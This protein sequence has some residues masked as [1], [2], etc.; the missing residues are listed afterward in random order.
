L[1][2]MS[3]VLLAGSREW[4]A[5]V[6]QRPAFVRWPIYLALSYTLAMF[7]IWSA[8]PRFVYFAF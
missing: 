7:G 6:Q 3:I 4:L 5:R 2:L 8:G 1:F